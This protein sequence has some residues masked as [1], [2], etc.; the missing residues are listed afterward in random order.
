[1]ATGSSA[2][3][4]ARVFAA[5]GDPMR[6]RFVLE[7]AGNAEKTATEI[8][9]A[10]GIS[11]ALLCHH[12]KILVDAGVVTKRKEAQTSYYRANCGVLEENLREVM[13][14]GAAKAAPAS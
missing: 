2:E 9:G 8:A 6:V 13:G 10:L 3:T 12:G 4:Q 1:M 14:R 7:L 5:L 11:L